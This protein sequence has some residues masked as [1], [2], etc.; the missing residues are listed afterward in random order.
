MEFV[1]T[2]NESELINGTSKVISVKG[3]DI[4]LFR[5]NNKITALGNSCL[6]KGVH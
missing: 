5:I 3:K 2:I 6:H 1:E 4:A